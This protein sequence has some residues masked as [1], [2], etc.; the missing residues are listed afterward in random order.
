MAHMNQLETKTCFLRCIWWYL[1][2][3][4]SQFY[5]TWMTLWVLQGPLDHFEGVLFSCCVEGGDLE[6]CIRDP[7]VWRLRHGKL[8]WGYLVSLEIDSCPLVIALWWVRDHCDTWN[9]GEDLIM[10]TYGPMEFWWTWFPTLDGLWSPQHLH[11]PQCWRILPTSCW[12]GQGDPLKGG[13]MMII[14]LFWGVLALFYCCNLEDIPFPP[15][16]GFLGIIS[17]YFSVRG[18]KKA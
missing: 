9:H 11:Q 18:R 1:G 7:I 4:P 13:L 12:L 15:W 5:P 17:Y 16:L 2:C 10:K 14:L 8:I 6:I 3:D